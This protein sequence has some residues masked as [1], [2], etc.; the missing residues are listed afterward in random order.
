KSVPTGAEWLHEVKFDGYRV[1]AHKVGSRVVIF[2]RNGHDFTGSS[3]SSCAM[4]GKRSV[5]EAVLDGEVVASEPTAVR[6]SPDCTSVGQGRPQSSYGHSICLHSGHQHTPGRA[7][8]STQNTRVRVP[9]AG[10][11]LSLAYFGSNAIHR[12]NGWKSCGSRAEGAAREGIPSAAKRQNKQDLQHR[13]RG[14]RRVNGEPDV[15][16]WFRAAEI[17]C[18][19]HIVEPCHDTD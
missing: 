5:K 17:Q 19:N 15:L 1:Q 16:E 6:T 4:E 13:D 2:S 7:T 12:R 18:Q 14:N 9:R 3:C 8:S 10:Q 11:R